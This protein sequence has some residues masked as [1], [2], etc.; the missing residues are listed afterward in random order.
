MAERVCEG[1]LKP[2]GPMDFLYGV[3]MPCTKARH[4]A[5]ISHKCSCGK[6]RRETKVDYGHRQEIRCKRCLGLV[7]QLN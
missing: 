1:C 2:L 4:K 6:Q 7:K 5:A 3:C